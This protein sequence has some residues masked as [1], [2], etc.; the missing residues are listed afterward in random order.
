MKNPF[1]RMLTTIAIIYS[2]TKRK[3]AL[4][5]WYNF[6][7]FFFCYVGVPHLEVMYVIPYENKTAGVI[8][9]CCK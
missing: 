5:L 8:E 6:T 1:Y 2:H 7:K 3:D 4:K 9:N